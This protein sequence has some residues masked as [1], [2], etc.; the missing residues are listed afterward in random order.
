MTE[1]EFQPRLIGFAGPSKLSNP[2]ALQLAIRRELTTIKETFGPRV[3]AVSRIGSG[4]NLLFLRVCVEQRIPM[5][6]I[7][8]HS[9]KRLAEDF[10]NIEEWTMARHMISVALAKYVVPEQED[11]NRTVH[12]YLLEFA[13]AFLFAWHGEPGDEKDRTGDILT[14]TRDLGIPARIIHVEEL[15]ARWSFEPD[16]QRGARHGFETRKDLL[17]FFDARLPTPFF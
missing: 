8:P 14:E 9:A 11:A 12:R 16:L 17:E 5:I 3:T 13:D 7:S 1:L 2:D 10:Q 4:A 6:L 15:N